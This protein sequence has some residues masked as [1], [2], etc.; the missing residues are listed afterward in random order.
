M[1]DEAICIDLEE[2]APAQ[3]KK[4]R[5]QSKAPVAGCI[6]LADDEDVATSDKPRAAKSTSPPTK[7][8]EQASHCTSNG[9]FCLSSDEE[10]SDDLQVVSS[11]KSTTTTSK[12][13]EAPPITERAVSSPELEER[14]QVLADAALQNLP[15]AVRAAKMVKVKHSILARLRS[16]PSFR[17]DPAPSDDSLPP[18]PPEETFLSSLGA[19]SQPA[20]AALGAIPSILPVSSITSQ[21]EQ[22]SPL[23]QQAYLQDMVERGQMAVQQNLLRAEQ[24]RL[25]ADPQL[26]EVAEQQR[27]AEREKRKA[28]W[29]LGAAPEP[30]DKPCEARDGRLTANG[31]ESSQ[32]Q[33]SKDRLKFLRLMGGQKFVDAA[34][35]LEDMDDEKVFEL[36]AGEW[37]ESKDEEE[38]EEEDFDVSANAQTVELMAGQWVDVEPKEQILETCEREHDLERQYLEGMSRQ[39]GSRRSGLGA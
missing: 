15:P 10:A 38:K 27:L 20:T 11:A 13:A 39:L 37:V 21:P 33:S 5:R 25:G 29:S 7:T 30:D 19:E 36:I 22:R 23:M 34:K 8:P 32:F 1:I 9:A 16:Q 26:Q 2:E 35:S 18:P 12:Q 3:R 4:R 6:D 14:A 28:L 17:L 24:Q 31:W